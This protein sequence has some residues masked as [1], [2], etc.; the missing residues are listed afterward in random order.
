MLKPW[1]CKKVVFFQVST[2]AQQGFCR[3]FTKLVGHNPLWLA[4]P[5]GLLAS[6]S[7][8]IKAGSVQLYLQH[9]AAWQ[10]R[11]LQDTPGQHQ[12]G[13]SPATPGKDRQTGGKAWSTVQAN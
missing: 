3:V 7:G 2:K 5:V 13:K 11:Q 10:L 12:A 9:S 1:L 8:A 4:V 6:G